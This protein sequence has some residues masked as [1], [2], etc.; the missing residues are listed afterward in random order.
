MVPA[1]RLAILPSAHL[2]EGFDCD[3]E[4]WGKHNQ[5]ATEAWAEWLLT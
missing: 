2:S 4:W 5:A 3:D 1:G